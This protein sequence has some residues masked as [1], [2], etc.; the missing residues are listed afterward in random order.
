MDKNTQVKADFISSI[1]LIVFSGWVL[2]LSYRMPAYERVGSYARPSLAPT[3][4]S[5]LLMFCG[6][7]LL[8][9]SLSKRGYRISI[10]KK[11]FKSVYHSK[12]VKHF[13]VVLGLV[14]VF[15]IFLG[16]MHFVFISCIYVFFNI[17]YFQSTALWK[18][19][20]ISGVSTVFIW[21]LFNYLFLIPL[22]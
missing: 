21:Y 5:V 15:Y 7:I 2:F 16:K 19:I 22:P 6:I 10:E 12:A 17:L 20:L 14:F 4:F 11:H 8:I 3:I 13:F 1:V 9:R 18:N